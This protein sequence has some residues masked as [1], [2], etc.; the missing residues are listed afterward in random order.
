MSLRSKLTIDRVLGALFFAAAIYCLVR[1]VILCFSIDIW[2]DELFSM[3]FSSRS[4][5]ELIGLTARDVHPPLYYLILRGFLL[6]GQSLGI[7]G[8]SQ[9][10]LAPEIV[11]KLVSVL[12][13]AL[14]FI[15]NIT[16]VR[17][18]FGF[19]TAG[20]FSF[21]IVSMPQMPEY[22][23]E[24]RMYSWAVFFVT[25]VMLHGFSLI[26]RMLSKSSTRWGIPDAIALWLY[27]AAAAYTHYYAAFC[28][29]I[30]YGI[31]VV[32]ML[33]YYLK[34]MKKKEDAPANVNFRPLA[35][36]IVSMNL[37]IISYI[38][39]ASVVLSQVG[40][41]KE[42]YWIQPVGLRSLG[43]CAKYLLKG[44]F[45]NDMIGSALAVAFFVLI[46]VLFI[47]ALIRAIMEKELKDI[48]MVSGF[49]MLPLL[50]AA[51]IIASILIRP[52]F[53]SRYMLPAYGAFWLSVSAMASAEF[54]MLREKKKLAPILASALMVLVL[55]VGAVDFKT[56]IGNEEYRIV[57][58]TRTRSLFEGIGSDTIIISNFNHVQALLSYY[59]N[60][61]DEEYKIFL[62][63]Q[64]PEPLIYETVPGLDAVYDPIDIANYLEGGKS[65]LFL[66]SFKSREVLLQEWKDELGIT[67][68]NEGSY[69]MERYWFDVFRLG[70]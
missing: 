25:A 27:S 4:A 14:L 52:V 70:K 9:G 13:F 47:R 66:G 51:G 42:N 17:K 69:L 28:V 18:H 24:I 65:V 59:L 5:A 39:W 50:V 58:M 61:G 32:L 26:R 55:V 8:R 40:A 57:N 2:Y 34:Y 15:Y 67:S 64:E 6:L 35:M 53:V 3:E 7:V 36:V 49:L 62:Y 30:T 1:S 31:L 10:M 45:S 23:T 41:V 37:T 11:A 19:L 21:A 20:I 16:T 38:P 56:F 12:P 60:M 54:E 63:Q 29:G 22:T 33:V 43:S 46:A 48:L 44:Y 68:E